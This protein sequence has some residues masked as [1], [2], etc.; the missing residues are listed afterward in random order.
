MQR[1]VWVVCSATKENRFESCKKFY[2]SG[3][4]HFN[5]NFSRCVVTFLSDLY[6]GCCG[7]KCVVACRNAFCFRSAKLPLPL[8]IL[9]KRCY[10]PLGLPGP[11]SLLWSEPCIISVVHTVTPFLLA[12]SIF[13]NISK[14]DESVTSLLGSLV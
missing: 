2:T 8:V 4:K 13:K 3:C 9:Q 5:T 1:A 7:S 6:N 10:S 14:L 11:R 12:G